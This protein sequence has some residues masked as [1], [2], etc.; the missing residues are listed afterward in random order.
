MKRLALLL[1]GVTLQVVGVNVYSQ[2][3]KQE[4]GYII[5]DNQTVPERSRKSGAEVTNSKNANG[6]MKRHSESGNLD[7]NAKVSPKF[8]V[9]PIDVPVSSSN[10]EVEMYW[11]TAS[12]WAVDANGNTNA[13]AS[14]AESPTGCA[15]YAGPQGGEVGQWRLPTQREL[16]LIWILKAPLESIGSAFNH[17]NADPTHSPYWSGTESSTS[18]QSS[19]FVDFSWGDVNMAGAHK[20]KRRVRCVRD[21]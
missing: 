5:I 8:A 19:W 2:V 17:L 14:I 10:P 4:N 1:L 12:G 3:V 7:Y 13:G 6:I 9:S 20:D 11:G 16:M 15:A 18:S 21:M